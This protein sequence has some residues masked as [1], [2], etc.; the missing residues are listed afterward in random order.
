VGRRG[1]KI[2]QSSDAVREGEVGED[3]EYDESEERSELELERGVSA[4]DGVGTGAGGA[5][6]AAKDS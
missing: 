5:A 6:V 2:E 4:C 1:W 3:C